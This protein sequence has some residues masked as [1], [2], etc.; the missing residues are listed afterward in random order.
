MT[1]RQ[2][3]R[4]RLIVALSIRNIQVGQIIGV[5]EEHIHRLVQV[6]ESGRVVW[7]LVARICGGGITEEDALDLSRELGSHF[8]IVSHDITVAG[9]CDQD[10][11]ALRIRFEDLL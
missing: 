3:L 8:R 2:V 5:Q 11:L 4:N 6:L 10:K 9:V 1:E 7:E